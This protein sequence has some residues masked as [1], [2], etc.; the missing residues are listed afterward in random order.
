MNSTERFQM[1][2][3]LAVSLMI[4]GGLYVYCLETLAS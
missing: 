4:Q 1:L 2:F 3:A